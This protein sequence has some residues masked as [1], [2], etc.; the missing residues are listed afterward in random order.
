MP[1]SMLPRK[2][3]PLSSQ[4]PRQICKLRKIAHERDR[5]RAALV[6]RRFREDLDK[7]LKELSLLKTATPISPIRYMMSINSMSSATDVD[8]LDELTMSGSE[9]EVVQEVDED[10]EVYSEQENN[11]MGYEDEAEGDELFTSHNGS[12]FGSLDDIPRSTTHL[13]RSVASSASRTP[14]SSLL[15]PTRDGPLSHV[16]GP[17]LQKSRHTPR[18]HNMSKRSIDSLHALKIWATCHRSCP[19]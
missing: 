18:S 8:S 4:L 6:E 15:R 14:S 12:S 16:N 2:A 11:L 3:I 13:V 9:L 5:V 7:S 10:E 19:T 17:S 1:P